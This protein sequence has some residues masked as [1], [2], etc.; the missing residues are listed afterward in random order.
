MRRLVIAAAALVAAGTAGGAW[1]QDAERGRLL[2]ERWCVDCHVIGP[3]TAGGD[4]G[5][6]FGTVANRDGQTMGAIT[7]WLF[8]PH[9]PM[10]DLLLSPAEFRDLAAYVMSLRDE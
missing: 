8:E 7:A 6:A 4:I 3:D 5:P 9:P 2:A 10:P 1:A